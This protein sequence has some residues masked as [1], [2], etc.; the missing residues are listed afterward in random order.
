MGSARCLQLSAKHNAIRPVQRRAHTGL[1]MFSARTTWAASATRVNPAKYQK[2]LQYT[3]A[4]GAAHATPAKLDS[5]FRLLL[6][7]IPPALSLHS[8]FRF[9]G[10]GLSRDSGHR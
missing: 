5:A 10:D 7:G 6:T 8:P 9:L 1:P 2:L 3:S 4:L